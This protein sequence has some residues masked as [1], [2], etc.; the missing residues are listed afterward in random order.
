MDN[1]QPEVSIIIVNYNVKEL[2]IKCISSIYRFCK[3][4]FEIILIDNNSTDGSVEAVKKDFPD[5]VII[6]NNYNAGFPKANN[7][8]FKIAI[9]KY[10]FML[11][12]DAALVEDSVSVL[13]EFLH[14]DETVAMVVP[15]LINPDGSLQ[16]SVFRFPKIKYIA[17]EMFYLDEFLKSKSYGDKDLTKSLMVDSAIGAAMFFHKSLLDDIGLLNEKLFWI[18]DI[19]FCFRIMQ[20]NKQILYVPQTHVLHYIGQSAKKNYNISISNQIINKIKFYKVHHKAYQLNI[21][22]LLSLVNVLMRLVIFSLI[23][24]FNPIGFL[25][26]KAYWFTLPLVFTAAKTINQ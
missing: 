5:T 25:K 15:Q 2:L 26:M 12:P 13:K 11:N 8:G 21:V 24:P 9:G 7:Q 14:V 20:S 23:A 18:E 22:I 1:L 3:T 6:E 17:A 19:D 16:H 10:I 4:S